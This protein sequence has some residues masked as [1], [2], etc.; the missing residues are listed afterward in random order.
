MQEKKKRYIELPR[1]ERFMTAQSEDIQ[2][3]YFEIVA[4]LERE[5]C[6]SMPQGEKL[7]GE[8]LFAIRIINT[9]NVRVFYVYGKCDK[10]YGLSAYEKKTRMIPRKEI[11]FARKIA[12]LLKNGGRI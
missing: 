12:R 9:G 10:I 4:E 5:G 1:V 7:T 11:D 3:E 2:D 6:L 8:N